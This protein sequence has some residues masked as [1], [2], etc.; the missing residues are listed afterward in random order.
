MSVASNF[1]LEPGSKLMC[2]AKSGAGKTEFCRKLLICADEVF[3]RPVDRIVFYYKFAPAWRSDFE[4][5]VEFTRD[6][7]QDLFDDDELTK[8]LVV[9][10]CDEKDFPAVAD[11]FLRSGRHSRTATVV[12]Y[13]SLFHK[14][15]HFRSMMQNADLLV[16]FHMTRALY[17]VSLLARQVFP[18]PTTSREVVALYKKLTSRKGG[19]LLFDFRLDCGEYPLRSQ[20]FPRLENDFESV[21]RT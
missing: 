11:I 18:D 5:R 1:K 4:G 9:D 12:N 2:V 17:Q 20:V 13:Q 14:S 8:L 3:G 19:Y 6:L 16:L 21:Y 15:Q 10:D 7:P